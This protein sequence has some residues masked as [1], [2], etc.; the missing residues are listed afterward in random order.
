[1]S[2]NTEAQNRPAETQ[3]K[4]SDANRPGRRLL[5]VAIV[6]YLVVLA[7]FVYLMVLGIRIEASKF[8]AQVLLIVP[9][10][11]LGTIFGLLY[12]MSFVSSVSGIPLVNFSNGLSTMQRNWRGIVGTVLLLAVLCAV[13]AV[14]T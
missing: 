11:L 13:L 2:Q 6:V 4:S 3:I 10:A 5:D 7:A 12:S 9:V 1:M 8:C 14:A